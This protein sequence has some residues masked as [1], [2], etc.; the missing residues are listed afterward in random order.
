METYSPELGR[1]SWKTSS[2]Y[3]SESSGSS[4]S[5]LSDIVVRGQN[6][7]FTVYQI[8]VDSHDR[9]TRKLA[10]RH[11]NIPCHN[12]E[13][14]TFLHA[15]LAP[16]RLQQWRPGNTTRALVG[17]IGG[18]QARLV[19]FYNARYC[20]LTIFCRKI[21]AAKH[22]ISYFVTHCPSSISTMRNT[23]SHNMTIVLPSTRRLVVVK[24]SG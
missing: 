16:K 9:V 13:S 22:N 23:K 2:L 19:Y 10:T 24:S 20:E 6:T 21:L 18:W 11:S 17:R 3:C 1:R 8:K 14:Y 4:F 12:N 5:A 15:Y 7:N